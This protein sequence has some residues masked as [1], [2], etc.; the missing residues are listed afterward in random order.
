ML[1][2]SELEHYAM[3]ADC[4]RR[5]YDIAMFTYLFAF[6]HFGSELLIFRSARFAPAN[7][8]PVVVSSKSRRPILCHAR[9]GHDDPAGSYSPVLPAATSLIWMFTQYKFYVRP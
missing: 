4:A 3:G 2:G 6:F 5:I 1:P 7:L 9:R 8:S